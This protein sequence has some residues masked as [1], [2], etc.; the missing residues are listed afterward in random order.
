MDPQK[1]CV[2]FRAAA[3]Q[4]LPPISPHPQ[5]DQNSRSAHN[6]FQLTCLR[7]LCGSS[8]FWLTPFQSL[9]HSFAHSVL[10]YS[11]PLIW[12]RTL[13][14]KRPGYDGPLFTHHTRVPLRNSTGRR[15]S[16]PHFHFLFSAFYYQSRLATRVTEHGPPVAAFML[17]FLSYD[18]ARRLH[19]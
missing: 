11:I 18:P 6:P 10:L 2:S 15:I 17:Q 19:A 8:Q 7:T 5:P 13:S 4:L 1:G 9:A 16:E 14:G 12:F 3:G